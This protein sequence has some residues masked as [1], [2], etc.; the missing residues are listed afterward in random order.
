MN[1]PLSIPIDIFSPRPCGGFFLEGGVRYAQTSSDFLSL[2]V[3]GTSGQLR[4]GASLQAL[5]PQPGGVPPAPQTPH[6]SGGKPWRPFPR[7][8]RD[9]GVRLPFPGANLS[10]AALIA[11]LNCA[12]FTGLS[13]RGP[14]SSRPLDH[15]VDATDALNLVQP[16]FVMQ[17]RVELLDVDQRDALTPGCLPSNAPRPPAGDQWLHEVKQDG[18]G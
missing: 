12:G 2:V 5:I 8:A 15:A 10:Q 13:F 4:N 6:P 11:S 3:S 14:Q 9:G 7:A 18:L 17:R 16:Y 1:R